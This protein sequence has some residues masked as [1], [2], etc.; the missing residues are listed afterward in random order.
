MYCVEDSSLSKSP[1]NLKALT[2]TDQLKLTFPNSKVYSISLKDRSAILPGG[3][4]SDGSFWYD[5]KEGI[6]K[7]SQFYPN[8][9]FTYLDAFNSKNYAKKNKFKT[10]QSMEK[11]FGKNWMCA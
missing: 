8:S 10:F 6:L 4:L 7:T 1:L 5:E 3:H 2:I 9:M 11:I